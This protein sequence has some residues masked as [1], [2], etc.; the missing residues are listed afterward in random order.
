MVRESPTPNSR[1]RAPIPIFSSPKSA[2]GQSTLLTPHEGEHLYTAN[3]FS[4]DGRKLLITSNAG[5][6]YDNVGLLDIASEE[7]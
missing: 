5:N 2:T 6:G 7:D 3:E 4:P 1:P